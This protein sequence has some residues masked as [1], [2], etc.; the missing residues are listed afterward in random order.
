MSFGFKVDPSISRS[1]T[2]AADRVEN[3]KSGR[4]TSIKATLSPIQSKVQKLI[5]HILKNKEPATQYQDVSEKG[6]LFVNFAMKK[7]LTVSK[8]TLPH[9]KEIINKYQGLTTKVPIKASLDDIDTLLQ[10]NNE[11][12]AKEKNMLNEI[13]NSRKMLQKIEGT[14][15]KKRGQVIADLVKELENPNSDKTLKLLNGGRSVV[16]PV[17]TNNNGSYH[18]ITCEVKREMRDGKECTFLCVH[19]RGDGCQHA[20]HGNLNIRDENGDHYRETSIE[21]EIKDTSVLNEAFFSSLAACEN[22]GGAE[23]PYELIQKTIIDA[24]KGQKVNLP[25]VKELVKVLDRSTPEYKFFALHPNGA[26]LTELTYDKNGVI[27]NKVLAKSII[28]NLDS[29]DNKGLV[30]KHPKLSAHLE[31]LKKSLEKGKKDAIESAARQLNQFIQ[32]EVYPKALIEQ[33]LVHSMQKYGTCTY[34]NMSQPE[35]GMADPAT[36]RKLKRFGIQRRIADVMSDST[37]SQKDKEIMQNIANAREEKLT[38][39]IDR[40]SSRKENAAPPSSPLRSSPPSYQHVMEDKDNMAANMAA[41]GGRPPGYDEA[42]AKKLRNEAPPPNYG[43]PQARAYQQPPPN[44]GFPEAGPGPARPQAPKASADG[45]NL[46]ATFQQLAQERQQIDAEIKKGLAQLSNLFT[47]QAMLKTRLSSLSNQANVKTNQMP[48]QAFGEKMKAVLEKT[49]IDSTGVNFTPGNNK[50]ARVLYKKMQ[51]LCHPDKLIRSG[52][53][54]EEAKEYAKEINTYFDDYCEQTCSLLKIGYTSSSDAKNIVNSEAFDEKFEQMPQLKPQAD[55][56]AERIKLQ[57]ELANVEREL[58]TAT[59]SQ[60][61]W[62]DQLKKCDQK[63]SEL[64]SPQPAMRGGP[65]AFGADTPPQKVP[66]SNLMLHGSFVPNIHSSEEAARYLSQPHI[67]NGD[68]ILRFSASQNRFYICMKMPGNQ[69]QQQPVDSNTKNE[70]I[71][72]LIFNMQMK[73]FGRT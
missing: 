62:E 47:K 41:H 49:G 31:K 19:N 54:E 66:G 25:N 17:L 23:A 51:L 24:G 61:N 39:Q 57:Q 73:L 9:S 45:V 12:T 11:L 65:S 38:A 71:N 46:N 3:R 34:S 5:G 52:I 4:F 72:T 56:Q 14:S 29:Q 13:K 21:I 44:Y 36:V 20:L 37:I 22:G 42:M 50:E 18:Y 6:R 28:D 53:P 8:K 2:T 26:K 1:N 27:E 35:K 33:G 7:T 58:N 69:I 48:I 40:L 60:R 43:S 68:C 64:R 55:P 16:I 30:A 32:D 10:D 67:K 59:Q 70:E 63:M 15:L